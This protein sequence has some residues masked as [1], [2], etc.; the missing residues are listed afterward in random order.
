M[1]MM[2]EEKLTENLGKKS[3]LTKTSQEIRPGR[4]LLTIWSRYLMGVVFKI[5]YQHKLAN[6]TPIKK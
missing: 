2:V 4:T 3:G 5:T 1:M 6:H